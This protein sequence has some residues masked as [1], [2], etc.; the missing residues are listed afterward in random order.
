MLRSIMLRSTIALSMI[1]A[2]AACDSKDTT[3]KG[4]D[5]GHEHGEGA[6]HD[7]ECTCSKGKEGAT[8]WCESC[9]VG[10]IDGEKNA[11]KAKVDEAIAKK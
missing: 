3:A 6:D 9:N 4:D 11:D 10:Y 2:V 7:H 8:V 1:L 5:H